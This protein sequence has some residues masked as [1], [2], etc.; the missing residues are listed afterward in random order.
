MPRYQ[1]KIKMTQEFS[2]DRLLREFVFK[3]IPCY[4]FWLA[5]ALR[6][7]VIRSYGDVR[8]R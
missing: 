1:I 2:Y 8:V 5:A 3:A 7:Y 6:F 4:V